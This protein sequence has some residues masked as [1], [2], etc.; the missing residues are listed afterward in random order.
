MKFVGGLQG[1]E[2]S[3]VCAAAS[4]SEYSLPQIASNGAL[5]VSCQRRQI[6]G[7]DGGDLTLG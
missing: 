2:V 7:V 1:R 6:I 3:S 5:E 4:I